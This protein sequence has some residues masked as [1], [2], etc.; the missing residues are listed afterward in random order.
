MAYLPMGARGSNSQK[1]NQNAVCVLLFNVKKCLIKFRV[2][3]DHP[4]YTYIYIHIYIYIFVFSS[5]YFFYM[6]S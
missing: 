3:V 4:V 1:R 6:T 2:D 5:I